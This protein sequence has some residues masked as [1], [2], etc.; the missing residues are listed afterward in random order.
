MTGIVKIDGVVDVIEEGKVHT[1]QYKHYEK[2]KRTVPMFVKKKS[3][4]FLPSPA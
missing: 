2:F 3:A 4:C 1:S